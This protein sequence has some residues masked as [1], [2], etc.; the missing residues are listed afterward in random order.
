MERY[1]RQIILPNFGIAAQNQLIKSKVLVIGAGGLGVPVLQY[2]AAAGIG[3]LGICDGDLLE[4]SNLQRQVLYSEA[5]I[6][7]SKAQIAKEKIEKLNSEIRLNVHEFFLDPQ[8]VFDCIEQ[9]DIVVDC[10]D[11]F[12]IR[13]LLNDVCFLLK[14]PLVYASIFQFEAQLSVF[15][16]GENSFSLRDIFP[17][18]PD[19]NAVPNCNEAGVLGTLAGVTGSLQANEVIKIITNIG[20][21]NSGKLLLFNSLNNQI[22]QLS[23]SK[24]SNTFLPTS[25]NQI[26]QNNYGFFCSDK[27]SLQK[28][29][30]LKDVLSQENS[31]LIDVREKDEL[32]KIS[33]FPIVEIPLAELFDKV[34][35]LAEFDTLVFICKS[36]MRSK[37]ALTEILK[38]Y[39]EKQLF[40]CEKG[41]KIIEK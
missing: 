1:S 18:I 3:E 13:Y 11:H 35:L 6:G 40:H 25:K 7:K 21:V 28:L 31:V 37:K 32:P 15:H 4:I 14:K 27:F 33:N 20:N 17:E 22:T 36:G 30:D 29:K 12:S 24:N 2:L 38:I 26:L 10:T 9:Y 34:E 8:T 5:E 39:P 41:L 19:E 23:I 16:Y